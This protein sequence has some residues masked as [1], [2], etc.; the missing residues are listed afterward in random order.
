M[1]YRRV[2]Y[3][4]MLIFLTVQVVFASEEEVLPVVEIRPDR[5][6]IYPERMELGGEETL[7]DMLQLYPDFITNA[8]DNW[9]EKYEMRIDNGPYGGDVRFLLN[10][11][12]ASR[13]MIK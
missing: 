11:M 9:L 3:F 6:V 7:F 5:V 2:L 10:E 1:K 4:F 8:Y 13:I 12:K